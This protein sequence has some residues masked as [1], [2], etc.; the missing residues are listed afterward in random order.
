MDARKDAGMSLHTN[1]PVEYE[2]PTLRVIGAVADLTQWGC[3]KELGGSDGF[4]FQGTHLVC[5]SP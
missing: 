4:I 3:Q 5:K 1:G 2:R